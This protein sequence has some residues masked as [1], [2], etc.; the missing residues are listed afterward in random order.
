MNTPKPH[1]KAERLEY[2]VD[3]ISDITDKH[4]AAYM[5]GRNRWRDELLG[6]LAAEGI[7]SEGEGKSVCNKANKK[8]TEDIQQFRHR[9]KSLQLAVA[10]HAK[11]EFFMNFACAD[12]DE[13]EWCRSIFLTSADP[14]PGL[15]RF[16]L[17]PPSP[18]ESESNPKCTCSFSDGDCPVHS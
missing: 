16:S 13:C 7:G 17:V 18:S 11:P 8:A 15:I 5:G 10:Y 1:T 14:Q 4:V 9:H 12:W 6:L 3:A 2:L